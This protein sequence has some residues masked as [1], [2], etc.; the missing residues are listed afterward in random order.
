MTLPQRQL[1]V[2][3]FNSKSPTQNFSLLNKPFDDA[4]SFF[5]QNQ[6]W[7]FSY[8]QLSCN[9]KWWNDFKIIN[10][11]IATE[12]WVIFEIIPCFFNFIIGLILL[13][14]YSENI[15]THVQA[16]FS[17]NKNL[18]WYNNAENSVIHDS[19]IWFN[20]NGNRSTNWSL[21]AASQPNR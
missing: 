18:S 13:D 21:F 10:Y 15:T 6:T 14:F 12:L 9:S 3:K 20:V 1:S 7:I 5:C 11:R 19:F 17:F 2:S 16:P 4:L 8:F